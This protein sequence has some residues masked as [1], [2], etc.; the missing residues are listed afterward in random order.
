VD[1]YPYW[2]PPFLVESF[3]DLPKKQAQRYFDWY[4][5]DIPNRVKLLEEWF[6]DKWGYDLKFDYSLN[7]LDPLWQ[8]FELHIEVYEMTEQEIRELN[9]GMSD[10]AIEMCLEYGKEDRRAPTWRSTMMAYDIG[11]YFGETLIRNLP[12]LHWG[13]LARPKSLLGV[14]EP[15]ILGFKNRDYLEPRSTMKVG[16]LRFIEHGPRPHFLSDLVE[17]WRE[18]LPDE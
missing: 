5:A 3:P 18:Y 7:S 8:A 1:E 4:V 17:V 16:C 6:N 14:N 2:E 13:F 12:A 15:V 10:Q 9:A 11:A